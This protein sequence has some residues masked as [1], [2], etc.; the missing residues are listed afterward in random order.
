MA[1]IIF[2]S[3]KELEDLIVS[4]IGTD[5]HCPITDEQIDG[6]Y[7]QLSLGNYGITDIVTVKYDFESGDSPRVKYTIIEVKKET[8]KNDSVAQLSRYMAGLRH[9]LSEAEI[10]H[11]WSVEGILIAPDVCS[12]GDTYFLCEQAQDVFLYTA[13]CDLD[14]GVKFEYIGSGWRFESATPPD[15]TSG[16]IAATSSLALAEFKSINNVEAVK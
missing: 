3:E 16:F 14:I 8:I 11:E 6:F 12:K 1:R 13:S 5:K 9:I 10:S 7:Q 2:D 15:D 4:K